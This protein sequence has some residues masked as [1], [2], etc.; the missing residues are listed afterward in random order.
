MFL[1]SAYKVNLSDLLYCDMYYQ[2]VDFHNKSFC[3]LTKPYLLFIYAFLLIFAFELRSQ[4]VVY[5]NLYSDGTFNS[6]SINTNLPVGELR[7][8]SGVSSGGATYSVPL[9]VP[10]GTNGVA[11]Q[12]NI[13]YNSFFGDG[14]LGQG[15]N[16][17]G[18]STIT[19]TRKT[20][21]FDGGVNPVDFSSNDR[22]TLDGTRL[23]GKS[24]TYGANGSTYATEQENFA[25]I[26]S[27]GTFGGDP[28]YFTIETKDG[29]LME[30]GNTVDARFLDITNTEVLTWRINKITYDDGNYIEFKYLNGDR[31]SRIDEINYTGNVLSGLLPYNKL[32]F[33]YVTRIEPA[34]GFSDITTQYEAGSSLQN[35]F[36]LDKI[37]ITTESGQAFK[38]Y[39]FKY[40]HNQTNS[41]LS[42]I[43]ESG[44]NGTQLNSTI[45][46]YGNEP[47]TLVTATSPVISGQNIDVFPGDFN[48]DGYS[49]MLV[50]TRN[51]VNNILYHT[52]AK[53]YKK[54]PD[55][56]SNN[57]TLGATLTPLP[58]YSTVS[59]GQRNADYLSQDFSGDGA[60]DLLIIRRS[61]SGND[62][63]DI[64]L[65]KTTNDANAFL[66]PV[67][68]SLPADQRINPNGKFAY[69]GDFNGDGISD[70]MV[71]GGNTAHVYSPFIYYGSNLSAI[72][73][74]KPVLS[75]SSCTPLAQWV[76]SEEIYIF[77]FN[78]DGK[79]DIM[80]I[81]QGQSEIFTLDS[82]SNSFRSIYCSGF[83]TIWHLVY[84]GD[85]NGDGKTDILSR[86][87]FSNNDQ[88]HKAISTGVG[89]VET[90]YYFNNTPN[91]N[92][93]Y[94]GDQVIVSDANGDG[95]QDISHVWKYWVNGSQQQSKIDLYYSTG[96]GFNSEQVLYA[97]TFGTTPRN[98]QFDFNGD[99]RSDLMNRWDYQYPFDMLYFKR[100][101]KERLIEKVKNGIGRVDQWSYKR[102][103]ETANFYARG[104]LTSHPLNNLQIPINF[105]YQHITP[106][107][108]GGS[109]TMQYAY[110]EAKFHKEGKGFLGLKK[111]TVDNITTGFRTIE[112]LDFN[113]TYYVPTIYYS[114]ERKI[115]DNSLLSDISYLYTFVNFGTKR[116]WIK[117]DQIDQ[118]LI[119]EGKNISTSNTWDNTHGNLTQ[120]ITYQNNI[121]S[122]TTNYTYGAFG[123]PVPSKI[124]SESKLYTRLGQPDYNMAPTVYT[125]NSKGQMTSKKEF[126]GLSKNVL[127][128]YTYNILGNLI[129]ENFYPNG[130]APR[131]TSQSFD[132]K[133]RYALTTTNVLGQTTTFAYDVRWGKPTSISS[134]TGLTTT[135]Q[136]DEFGRLTQTTVPQAYNVT[137]SYGWDVNAS[138]GTIHFHS[139]THPGK[140]DVKE[141]YDV[142]GRT[143][144]TETQ[145]SHNTTIVQKQTYD[146]KGNLATSTAPY[147]QGE[148]VLNTTFTYDAYNRLITESNTIGTTNYAYAYD[149]NDN[150]TVSTTN[151]ASQ[152]SSKT[153]DPTGKLITEV[154]YS[155]TINYTY[156][157][158]GQLFEAKS[159]SSTLVTIEY[160][161]Y[162]RQKK[163][164]D[165]SA[166]ITQYVYNAL[167]ELSSQTNAKGQTHNMTYDVQGRVTLRTGP[168]GTTTYEYYPS[169]SGASTNQVKKI[170]G[171]AGNLDEYTYNVNGW[172]SSRKET[173]DGVAYTSNYVYNLYGDITSKTFVHSGFVLNSFYDANGY[174]MELKNGNNSVTLFTNN[175]MNGYNQYTNYSLGNGKTSLNSYYFG[176]PTRFYTSGIQDLNL[177]WN[178][179][180]SNLTNRYDAIK[181][182][183]ENFTYDNQNRLLSS[184]ISGLSPINITYQ[185]NGNIDTKSDAGAYTYS[186]T[187]IFAV[188]GVTNTPNNIPPGD[189]NVTYTPYDQPNQITEGAYELTF[190]YGHDYERRKSLLKQG[191]TTI[192]TRYY[193]GGYE[194]D[195]TSSSTKH[196]HYINA[197]QGLVA[198][199]VRENGSDAFYYTYTDHL[200][201]IVAVT[202]NTG[203]V[204]A[205]Q[206]FDAWGRKRNTTTWAYTGVQA[207]P[208]W[209][210]RGYTGHEHLPQFGLVN[211]NG[212]LYD[213]I[214]GRML[215]VDN[216]V[217]E[218]AGLLGYNRYAYA[219]NNPLRFVDP[220]GDNP[221]I[222]VPILTG[223]LNV[224]AN[225]KK[226]KDLK[227]G[228]A[229]FGAGAV[230]GTILALSGPVTIPM[231]LYAASG[232][233][234]S[235][236][237]TTI[238]VALGYAPEIKTADDF[239]GYAIPQAM[240]AAATSVAGAYAS[241]GLSSVLGSWGWFTQGTV[242][243]L[244]ASELADFAAQGITPSITTA[245]G[246]A[247]YL[248]WVDD[249]ARGLA[250]A[251]A[252]KGRELTVYRVFGGDSRAAGFSWTTTHP[253][254]VTNFRNLAGLPSGG[255][256]GSTNTA[257]FMVEGKVNFNNIIEY[258]KA[259]K[260]DGNIGGLPEYIIDPQYV[261]LTN[262]SVLKP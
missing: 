139:T 51:V 56:N 138:E 187:K 184:A 218:S 142:L 110:E 177:N 200:G 100:Y 29:V 114:Q 17:T 79:D 105:V 201:S 236:L 193:F 197:G 64:K 191:G 85:F 98:I 43:I 146:A 248:G 262:F 235:F 33:N 77:D 20:I 144:K 158:H 181:N 154:D 42:E 55:Q 130:L 118:D 179:Q 231:G 4:N 82:Q 54:I 131:Y 224:W 214:V 260:L 137:E 159:G 199:V 136:Y 156:Y 233:A 9:E 34:T 170:T 147:K 41:L 67:S 133:G 212:R 255:A 244:S 205:E 90:N 80:L 65:Y 175:G 213:P 145:G 234:T 18:L 36:L 226:V 87:K 3:N 39:T 153:T 252:V 163:L 188:T 1:L 101:G 2:K 243:A 217:H 192:N 247:A 216:F 174:L 228:L 83:P 172:L 245:A 119:F 253:N 150:L 127:T 44:A 251:A 104:N 257:N 123:T 103:T 115:S 66:T 222:L 59:V 22:F 92:Q 72:F 37:T 102:L 167:G 195:V 230:G 202:N 62:L 81:K 240:F 15:W 220:D 58:G 215:S 160:D 21:Y 16:L 32:K 121:E 148:A 259:V 38:E 128:Q 190:Q 219:F 6:K 183:T 8:K 63:L 14:I 96:D 232:A 48:A 53:I 203:G 11:P 161:E 124:T 109:N 19:R 75:G 149:A 225:W 31:N 151:P 189:Q 249:V 178:H 261:K 185:N 27:F 206:N 208:D 106:N 69:P 168:E 46:K 258:R 10:P 68:F 107:G 126:D 28:Q 71:L 162:A 35:K 61:T 198:I 84:F 132:T 134:F 76:N 40:A 173:V 165:I 30:F 111:T 52:D 229:Y 204:V 176:V 152:V 239:L 254:S 256:S 113:T 155:G 70:L 196:I 95:K 74:N 99:G 117:T 135:F 169:G 207:V 97:K 23:I 250:S 166:G 223:A 210:Y 141:W 227:S 157:S 238:D 24:G 93:Y 180:S 49:D 26:T 60:D 13:V 112:V 108:I 45:Y 237:N 186:P 242:Q 91:V 143:K 86:G 246:K 5:Q 140:P 171:F 12:I 57:F 129:S 50:C 88:W 94:Y 211:M 125:Y 194:K 78:G 122:T 182:K 209:L 164:T 25:T 116:F 73:F 89:F 241:Q 47:S 7:G 221:L 120:T